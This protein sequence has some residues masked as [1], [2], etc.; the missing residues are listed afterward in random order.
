MKQ[1]IGTISWLAALL[2]AAPAAPQPVYES[3]DAAGPVFSDRPAAGAT[4]VTL[5]PLNRMDS[6]QP[7]P[8]AQAAPAAPAAPA[9]TALNIVQP[10]NGD[11]IHANTG[12][13]SVRLALEPALQSEL[14]DAIAVRLDGTPL[15][16]TRT[17]LH[18]DI[19]PEEWQSAASD[20]VEHQLEVAVVDRSGSAM[21]VS[22]GV[23]FYVH[24]ASRQ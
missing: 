13:F 14:G 5:P 21:I 7:P 4:E 16:T 15:R 2:F 20:S 10:A 9:Y 22:P 6:P 24:R 11:T 19:T 1:A 12:Q 23:R 8:A 3:R 18:F 17:K